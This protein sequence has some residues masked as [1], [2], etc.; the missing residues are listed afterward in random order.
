MQYFHS[1]TYNTVEFSMLGHLN[2]VQLHPTSFWMVDK[3]VK[4][5]EFNSVER[6]YC[7]PLSRT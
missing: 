6:K 3:R 4:H 7:F 1:K 5:V 2:S